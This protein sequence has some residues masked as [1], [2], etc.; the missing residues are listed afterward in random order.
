MTDE[1]LI[2]VALKIIV[3]EREVLVDSYSAD[4]TPDGINERRE[5]SQVKEMD[6]WIKHARLSL[7]RA[8]EMTAIDG[9]VKP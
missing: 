4:G 8:A 3:R 7:G 6:R 9:G 5:F 1:N 2:R